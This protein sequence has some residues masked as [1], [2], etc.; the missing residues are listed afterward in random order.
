[1]DWSKVEM[2]PEEFKAKT[3]LTY[4]KIAEICDRD[5]AHV[6]KWFCQ[7]KSHRECSPIHKRF[8]YSA[9]VNRYYEQ[10]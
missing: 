5:I 3:G 4:E 2:D 7:G 10:V 8:L 1:M 6:A 9:Y